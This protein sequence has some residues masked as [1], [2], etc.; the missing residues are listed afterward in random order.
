MTRVHGAIDSART[1]T[2]CVAFVA[3]V[4]SRRLRRRLGNRAL[5]VPV[6][7]TGPARSVRRVPADRRVRSHPL[8]ISSHIPPRLGVSTEVVE[9]LMEDSS[10]TPK[11]MAPASASRA[12][13][14]GGFA[15]AGSPTDRCCGPR[16]GTL[17]AGPV[18]PDSFS[19]TTD[20]GV[21]SSPTP[22]SA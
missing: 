5:T 8:S 22:S 17:G 10:P 13:R 18:P 21:A 1:T 16:S 14:S 7:L 3:V 9:R 20:R 6:G 4:S 12:D 2:T 15:I 11:T 19:P